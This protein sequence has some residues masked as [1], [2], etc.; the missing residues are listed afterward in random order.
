MQLRRSHHGTTRRAGCAIEVAYGS[1]LVSRIAWVVT[2]SGA[3]AVVPPSS[4]S[5]HGSRSGVDIAG[6]LRDLPSVQSRAAIIRIVHEGEGGRVKRGLFGGVAW[7]GDAA[8]DG[9]YLG[10]QA[11]TRSRLEEEG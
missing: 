9:E 10:E 6:L 5:K 4:S 2:A 11:G 8:E 7:H 1:P 3:S